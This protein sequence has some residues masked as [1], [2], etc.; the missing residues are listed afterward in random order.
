M[1]HAQSIEL[2]VDSDRHKEIVVKA[3][4]AILLLL[5]KHFKLNHIYQ[6][7]YMCQ[8]LYLEKCIP[9]VLDFFQKSKD[10]VVMKN[11]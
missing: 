4:S 9:I 5:L 10:Y 3:V 8:N 7:E 1:T 11:K 2:G 6:F